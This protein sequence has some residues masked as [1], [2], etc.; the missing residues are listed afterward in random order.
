VTGAEACP[1]DAT[2]VDAID[3]GA[4]LGHMLKERLAVE[5]KKWT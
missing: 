4:E 3:V 2:E 5:K 1:A